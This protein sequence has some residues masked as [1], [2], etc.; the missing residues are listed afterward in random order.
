MAWSS[1]LFSSLWLWL[2][3][4]G[5]FGAGL[6]VAGQL[7]QVRDD[8]A[9]REITWNEIIAGSTVQ[10]CGRDDVDSAVSRGTAE[11]VASSRY[12]GRPVLGSGL[13]CFGEGENVGAPAW[14]VKL[15][16]SGCFVVSPSLASPSRTEVTTLIVEIDARTGK[17]EEL[18]AP[19][20]GCTPLHERSIRD[21]GE[22]RGVTL[23]EI[24][25]VS[26]SVSCEDDVRP[27]VS[28]E[29][30]QQ[31]ASFA[32]DGRVALGSAF[33]CIGIG[34]RAG[35]PIWSVSLDPLGYE[36]PSIGTFG[37]PRYGAKL[38]IVT[39]DAMTGEAPEGAG[40]V[41]RCVEGTPRVPNF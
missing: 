8:G 15:N 9:L 19:R 35:D 24:N 16:P 28:R 20:M 10:G 4:L 25:S 3:V 32:N 11:Y 27:A 12:G 22:P 14:A 30:A 23:E 39:V 1:K 17:A 2:A 26:S 5:L 37:C 18:V 40:T 6:V 34:P 13:G 41:A 7:A 36:S 29:A 31:A 21:A 33:G 38:V